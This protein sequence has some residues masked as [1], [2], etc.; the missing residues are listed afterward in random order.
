MRTHSEQRV[1]SQSRKGM[2][3]KN[4]FLISSWRSCSLYLFFVCVSGFSVAKTKI[5]HQ[6]QSGKS[7]V[8]FTW[9]FLGLLVLSAC[10][11]GCTCVGNGHFS[12]QMCC[13]RL[14]GSHVV[15]QPPRCTGI[16]FFY[17]NVLLGSFPLRESSSPLWKAEYSVTHIL[18]NFIFQEIQ[19]NSSH[20][21]IY[22]LHLL[23]IYSSPTELTASILSCLSFCLNNNF[24]C[25]QALN[26]KIWAAQIQFVTFTERL[27]LSHAYN[28]LS[29][30]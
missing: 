21:Q 25:V 18:F 13:S 9:R 30:F 16:F 15:K 1:E 2:F 26:V 6:T 29:I 19:P 10:L 11:F 8:N 20:R 24:L 7:L 28:W 3:F 23:H 5:H 14:Q 12:E 17:W 22:L 27:S 4:S